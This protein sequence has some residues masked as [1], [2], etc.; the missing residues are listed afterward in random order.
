MHLS[1]KL[2]VR[3]DYTAQVQNLKMIYEPPHM[4]TNKMHRQK[5]K[6]NCTADQQLGFSFTD[7]IILLLL[8]P[9]IS[10]F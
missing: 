7:T 4:K 2:T 6:N 3:A 9:E 1:F 8:K 5:K 10:S